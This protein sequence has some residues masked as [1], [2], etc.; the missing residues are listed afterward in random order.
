M[1]IE[2]ERGLLE[3]FASISESGIKV[4]ETGCESPIRITFDRDR[5]P[6]AK[7]VGAGARSLGKIVS[8]NS[9]A[10]ERREG[11]R[12]AEAEWSEWDERHR[13]QP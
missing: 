3:G 12:K 11:M 10:V 6:A 4:I 5:L 2:A 13:S 7:N 9:A 1:A 8:P